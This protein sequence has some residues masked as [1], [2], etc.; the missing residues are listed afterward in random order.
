MKTICVKEKSTGNFYYANYGPNRLGN[1][2]LW[3]NGSFYSDKNFSKN[4]IMIPSEEYEVMD[5]S[6]IKVA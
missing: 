5:K 1:L 6:L 3:V 4:F 2:Q